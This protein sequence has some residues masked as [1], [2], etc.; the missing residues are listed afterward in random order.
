MSTTDSPNTTPFGSGSQGLPLEEVTL[1]GTTDIREDISSDGSRKGKKKGNNHK[2]LEGASGDGNQYGSRSD[3]RYENNGTVYG[4]SG[5]LVL[6][7]PMPVPGGYGSPYFDGNEITAYLKS[8][9]RCFKDHGIKSDAEKK[10]RTAE[11]ARTDEKRDIERLPE[12]KDSTSWKDFKKV[13]LKEYRYQDTEQLFHTIG[14][15]EKYVREFKD[16][17]D[18]GRVTQSQ[19]HDYCRKFREIGLNCK[20]KGDITEKAMTFKFFYALPEHLK[21]KAM[22][23]ATKGAKFDPDNMKTFAQIY[24]NVE[25]HCIMMRDME[26]LVQEQ[27]MGEL[28]SGFGSLDAFLGTKKDNNLDE[29]RD[30]S[31]YR[32]SMPTQN[33]REEK[34]IGVLPFIRAAARDQNPVRISD[35]DVDEITLGLEKLQ[36]LQVIAERAARKNMT[37]TVN[38]GYADHE[39]E[40]NYGGAFQGRPS[41][42]QSYRDDE[43]CKWCRN[44]TRDDMRPQAPH[45]YMNQCHDY[46]LFIGKGV[47]H[48]SDENNYICLGPWVQG[49]HPLPVQF[50]SDTPRRDQI[51]ARTINTK[52]SHISERREKALREEEESKRIAQQGIDP[53]MSDLGNL[54]AFED[55]EYDISDVLNETVL[56]EEKT[57]WVQGMIAKEAGIAPVETRQSKRIVKRSAPY[58]KNQTL[59]ERIRKEAS[60]GKAKAPQPKTVRFQSQDTQKEDRGA[61]SGHESTRDTAPSRKTT[62][63][64]DPRNESSLET[65]VLRSKKG[66]V[67]TLSKL[68]YSYENSLSKLLEQNSI[69]SGLTLGEMMTLLEPTWNNRRRSPN[70]PSGQMMGEMDKRMQNAKLGLLEV[71]TDSDD[72]EAGSDIIA[73]RELQV[74]LDGE[75]QEMACQNSALDQTGFEECFVVDVCPVVFESFSGYADYHSATPKVIITL[76][77]RAK[78]TDVRAVLDTGAEVSVMTLD[79]AVRFEI[80]ITYSS[81]MALRTIMGDKSRFVG[82]ADNVPVTIGNSVVRTRFYIMDRPGVKVILGFP[83]I[84]KA[85]V[86]LR[87]PSDLEDGPVYALFCDPTTGE[88]TSVKTNAETENAKTTEIVR[89][90]NEIGMIQSDDDTTGYSSDESEN[91]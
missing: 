18:R 43:T 34:P 15:L 49:A 22:R 82:F 55:D 11:Y 44:I 52:F 9:D 4:Q 61:E 13:L 30:H 8:L 57:A 31:A 7:H 69:P 65:R 76:T 32:R 23:F 21:L 27:G 25:N 5:A 36:I 24:E 46:K 68:G 71:S 81:G 66:V 41:R 14:Y 29:S 12:S 47:I 87:Y 89:A 63:P 19:I 85:R 77:G 3:N 60:Y 86:T 28:P 54:D 50:S 6:H 56:G 53:K 17:V 64:Q 51:I 78:L 42:Q 74:N 26:D 80:P 62:R 70:I 88:I 59:Q 2:H 40:V 58:D 45:K 91:W 84:R 37:A 83:F 73:E 79:A 38:M 16:Q 72:L 90:Q 67:E 39:Y 20:A 35:R 48:E 75:V 1:P 33:R 10:E